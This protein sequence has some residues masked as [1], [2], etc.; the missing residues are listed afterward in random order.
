MKIKQLI[1]VTAEYAVLATRKAHFGEPCYDRKL[2][3][4]SY[5]WA[6]LDSGDECVDEVVLLEIAPDGCHEICER[7]MVVERQV[8]PICGQKMH[9]KYNSKLTPYSWQECAACGY[10]LDTSSNAPD[11]ES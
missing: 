8:C 6:L 5:F 4:L 7:S 9:P 3:D 1:P 2:D 11:D 10:V